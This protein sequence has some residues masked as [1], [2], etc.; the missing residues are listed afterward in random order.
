MFVGKIMSSPVIVATSETT[1]RDA[2]ERMR[3]QNIG[4]IPVV[5]NDRPI[6]I[7]TDRDIVMNALAARGFALG[8]HTSVRAV[9]SCE[10]ITCFDDHDVVEAAALM[11]ERQVRRLLVLSHAGEPVGILS[12]G[13]IAEH[14]SEELAGQALGERRCTT[15]PW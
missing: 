5:Q 2:A 6:G 13:D 15:R 4:A 3:G 9:M 12:L 11:G 7:M 10:V 8:L 1:I 14:A